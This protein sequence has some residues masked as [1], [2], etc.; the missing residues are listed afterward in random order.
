[1][2]ASINA[3]A[4]EFSNSRRLGLNVSLMAIGY[5]IGVVVGGSI[6]A[7]LLKR[8]DWREVFWFGAAATASFIPLVFWLVPE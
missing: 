8:G 7:L 2:L 6:A 3:V 1:M 5:P 4:A